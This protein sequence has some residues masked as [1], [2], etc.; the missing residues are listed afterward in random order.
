MDAVLPDERGAAFWLDVITLPGQSPAL[1]EEAAKRL[2][3]MIIDKDVEIAA[4]RRDFD[5]LTRASNTAL[6]EIEELR[7]YRQRVIGAA[8][9]DGFAIV[10]ESVLPIEQRRPLPATVIPFRKKSGHD[11]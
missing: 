5:A 9:P 7:A 11:R 3:T 6:T 4:L 10:S 2:S 8:T 1:R